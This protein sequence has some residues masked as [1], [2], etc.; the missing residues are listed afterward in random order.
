[1]NKKLL[2]MIGGGVAILGVAVYML[3]LKPDP[4]PVFTYY[5]TGEPLVVNV[6]DT[7]RLFKT[8]LVLVVNSEDEELI[9]SLTKRNALIRDTALF[10]LR[11]LSETEI[12][13]NDNK[14]A[15]RSRMMA[16]L[17]ARLGIDNIVELLFNDFVVQ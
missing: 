1:M 13:E 8:S 17:N 11:D 12:L 14:D 10:I 3:F 15:L 2:I 5:S 7:G 6:K 16:E 9:G 4:E